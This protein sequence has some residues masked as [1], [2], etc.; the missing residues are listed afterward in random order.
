MLKIIEGN[1]Y[2]FSYLCITCYVIKILEILCFV[3]TDKTAIFVNFYI[4]WFEANL[5]NVIYK[6][7]TV[8]IWNEWN[9]NRHENF[10]WNWP[11]KISLFE[12][13][14]TSSSFLYIFSMNQQYY[15]KNCPMWSKYNAK[16]QNYSLKKRN[17]EYILH[18]FH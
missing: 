1:F 16:S 7:D 8:Y 2:S 13:I 17:L 4:L 12:K 10:L 3:K 15:K 11:T 5:S 6:L 9:I 18:I 14:N